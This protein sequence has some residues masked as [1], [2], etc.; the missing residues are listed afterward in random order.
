MGAWLSARS[1]CPPLVETALLQILFLKQ[2]ILI[3]ARVRI[4]YNVFTMKK[5]AIVEVAG[6]QYQ[7][8]EGDQIT[9]NNLAV[10]SAKKIKIDKVLLMANGKTEIG[11]PYLKNNTVEAEVVEN[12]KGE[13]VRVVTYKAKSRYR[14]VKGFRPQQTKLKITKIN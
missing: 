7:V 4:C 8:E 1:T 11:R 14:K 12:L 9:V 3:R 10:D 2:R 13:K 6:H 5:F